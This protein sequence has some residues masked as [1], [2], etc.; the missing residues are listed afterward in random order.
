MND[1]DESNLASMTFQGGFAGIASA[2][3]IESLEH[4]IVWLI[5]MFFVIFCD[6]V[7]GVRKSYLMGEQ[8]R[9]S[10]AVRLTLGK[11]V[12]DRDLP[13]PLPRKINRKK[14]PAPPARNGVLF[15]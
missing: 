2:F 11:M 14:H 5:V 3:I 10:K 15:C 8:V 12:P 7:C 4:M 9:F 6:L 1:M 13:V